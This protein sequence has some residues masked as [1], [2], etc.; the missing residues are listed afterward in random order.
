VKFFPRATQIGL[1]LLS[2]A[3]LSGSLGVSP[4]GAVSG[5][6][7]SDKNS[8]SLFSTESLAFPESLGR[9]ERDEVKAARAQ[10]LA[11]ASAW[12]IDPLQF[13]ATEAVTI[14]DGM[15]VVRFTQ[16]I[17]GVEVANSLLAVTVTSDGSLL[18]FTK[19]TSD[20]SETTLPPITQAQA[21]ESLAN[22]L[23]S[24]NQIST[25]EVT[26]PKIESVIVDDALVDGV[27][28]GKYLA[29]RATTSISGDT[30][31]LSMAYLSADGKTVLSNL[32][33][34]R[35]I[36]AD[37]FVCDLQI[38]M[39]TPGYA[40]PTGVTADIY[41]N[42]YI[43]IS[44]GNSVLPLC[45]LNTF[46]LGAPATEI[47]KLNI[48]R[49]WDYFSTVL[50]QDINEEKYLGNISETINGDL[51]PRISAFVDICT[52]NGTTGACPYG[53]AFWVPW[54]STDCSSGACSGIFLG[55]DFDHAD[56]V[57]AHELAH[58][59]TFAL[60]FKSAMA[61]TS[62]TAALS[63]AISDIFGES[64]DQLN[65]TTG[66]L[67]DSNWTMGEDAKVGG[68]RNLKKPTVTKIDKKWAPGDSHENS[69]PVNKLAYLL[70]NGGKV[71]KIKIKSL[72]SVTKDG[73]CDIPDECTGIVR[74]SQLVF[75]TT[76]KLSATANYFDF[77]KQMM[78]SCNDFVANKTAGFKKATCKNVAA[79][80]KAQGFTNF[81]ITGLT[82][83]GS[84]TRGADTIITANVRGTT[85]A[86]VVGQEMS[87]QIQRGSKW[88]T[89]GKA[90]TDG[91]GVVG[92][93]AAWT[94]S[95]TYR[96]ISKTNGGVF[97]ATGKTAKVRVK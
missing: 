53:N 67:P 78:I 90:N 58:G 63:E 61:E 60:A 93:N 43:N 66:E 48:V 5:P 3:L 39:A 10:L 47:G 24:V 84:V 64:M 92:F 40:L 59:V 74:M 16:F 27:P 32:L 30:T 81:K 71:G 21:I 23:A 72:G 9:I 28:A 37:P 49:T 73:L 38:D 44:T 22:L 56:D 35:G 2:F 97:S 31:S 17:G 46:G 68:Y 52:T 42:R 83:L 36:T 55:K 11:H 80:L 19:S 62:E 70:A 89:V 20:F 77:G 26:V 94:K 86:P 4:A 79:A 41:N 95:A 18:S 96:I 25:N 1:T 82:K 91:N 12:G 13:K 29:W 8:D 50:G 54:T 85:G 14:A 88:K 45:G 6:N 69:G 15:S 65:V 7:P 75:A 51:T 76:S 57:I 87:F 33:F 34:V